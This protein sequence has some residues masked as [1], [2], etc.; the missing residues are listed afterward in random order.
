LNLSFT[1]EGTAMLH[2]ADNIATGIEQMVFWT[3]ALSPVWLFM[4]LLIW[5]AG[6]LPG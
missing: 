3:I 4:Q 2:I 1:Q 6:H 5:A